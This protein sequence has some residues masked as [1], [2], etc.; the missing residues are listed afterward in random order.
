[1][2]ILITL[3]DYIFTRSLKTVSFYHLST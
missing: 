1:M 2:V 3:S